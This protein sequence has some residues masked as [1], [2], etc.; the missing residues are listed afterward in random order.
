MPHAK[1]I[2]YFYRSRNSSFLIIYMA[3]NSLATKQHILKSVLIDNFA[4]FSCNPFICLD[5]IY[6]YLESACHDEQ[7]SRQSFILHSRIVELWQ[8]TVRKVEK[9]I[10]PGL[11]QKD[12]SGAAKYSTTL[13][14]GYTVFDLQVSCSRTWLWR[15]THV[16]MV[17]MSNLLLRQSFSSSY[18]I[19]LHPINTSSYS[20]NPIWCVATLSRL[21]VMAVCIQ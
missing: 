10:K 9:R 16:T 2:C 19:P 17:I 11:C 6:I 4:P 14:E 7:N 13:A 21:L 20:Q 18:I 3:T 12:F 8:F 1:P 15:Y 5:D